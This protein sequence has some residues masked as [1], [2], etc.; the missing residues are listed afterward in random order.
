MQ[1][2]FD[3]ISLSVAEK[4]RESFSGQ[5][6]V[7]SMGVPLLAEDEQIKDF[8]ERLLSVL[9]STPHAQLIFLFVNEKENASSELKIS[10]QRVL[11][12]FSFQKNETLKVLREKNHFIIIINGTHGEWH[13]KAKEGVGRARRV[14]GD[15]AL[16]FYKKG[17]LTSPLH[18]QSDADVRLPQDYFKALLEKSMVAGTYP[19]RHSKGFLNESEYTGLQEYENFLKSYVEGLK[20]ASSPYAFWALGSTLIFDLRAYEKIR[21]FPNVQ[22]G[23][24]FYFLSKMQSQGK[25]LQI[26][27]IQQNHPFDINLEIVGRKSTRV[28]FGTGRALERLEKGERY[29]NYP[30]EVFVKLKNILVQLQKLSEH[31]NVEEFFL[32]IPAEEHFNLKELKKSFTG[33]FKQQASSEHHLRQIHQTFEGLQTFRWVREKTA[34]LSVKKNYFEKAAE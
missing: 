18:R 20:F 32:R 23:E 28:P 8:Y 10:N 21:G 27:E 6:F 4:L 5:S 25:V 15:L 29:K 14:L 24:D 11:E 19:F 34:S 3:L 13:L 2:P 31:R 33:I 26:D 9:S 7:E 16:F 12:F 17:A 30:Q 1:Y 22:A